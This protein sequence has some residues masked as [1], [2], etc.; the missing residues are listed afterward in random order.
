MR[1][2]FSEKYKTFFL[3]KMFLI[4]R[5]VLESVPSRWS[6]HYLQDGLYLTRSKLGWILLGRLSQSNSETIM[7]NVMFIMTHTSTLLPLEVNHLANN[8]ASDIFEPNIEDL[9]FMILLQSWVA[10][11]RQR[12]YQISLNKKDIKTKK[13]QQ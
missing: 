11:T 4:L 7:N 10:W 5:L 13:K 3:G 2:F 9:W 8:S 6:F 1:N 12:C